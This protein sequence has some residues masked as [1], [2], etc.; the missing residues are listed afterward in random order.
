MRE[1]ARDSGLLARLKVEE[2]DL[3]FSLLTTAIGYEEICK[4]IGLKGSSDV[5]AAEINES[6]FEDL[7]TWIFDKSRG[8]T[9]LGDSRNLD[10]LARIVSHEKSLFELRR[11]TT[12]EQ[13]DLFTSGPLDTLR[14]LMLEAE[15]RII[16]AQSTLSIAD[17]INDGD[18]AQADRLR[19]ACI[20]LHSSLQSLLVAGD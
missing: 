13:A 12:L 19:K 20:A 16:S 17:G 10:K 6:E 11:G 7:F 14:S 15:N 4:F 8:P 3:P 5:D 2:D 18:V 9:K 1:R